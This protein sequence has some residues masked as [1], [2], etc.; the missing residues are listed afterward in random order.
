MPDG[1]AFVPY[2]YLVFS[3]S[4]KVIIDLV[5]LIH[6]QAAVTIQ[7]SLKRVTVVAGSSHDFSGTLDATSSMGQSETNLDTIQSQPHLR[8][9]IHPQVDHSHLGEDINNGYGTGLTAQMIEDGRLL[10]E[11]AKQYMKYKALEDAQVSVAEQAKQTL[12]LQ[13]MNDLAQARDETHRVKEM[14]DIELARQREVLAQEQA[15]HALQQQVRI[16]A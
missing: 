10:V 16:K 3:T 2:V 1:V 8:S 7:K 13:M 15:E 4:N 6:H 14:S 5:H 9:R 11:E 12:R